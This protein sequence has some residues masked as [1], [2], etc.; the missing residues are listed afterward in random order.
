VPRQ[1]LSLKAQHPDHPGKG[2]G[3][4]ARRRRIA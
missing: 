1:Y 2:D 3:P 4:A